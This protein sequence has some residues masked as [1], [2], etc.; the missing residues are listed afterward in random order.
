M[1]RNI[2]IIDDGKTSFQILCCFG[3]F[4]IDLSIIT[5]EQSESEPHI[6]ANIS[7]YCSKSLKIIGIEYL[8]IPEGD[9]P[10][11]P[12]GELASI[13]ASL[14]TLIRLNLKLRELHLLQY[15]QTI[16]NAV[17]QKNLTDNN[18]RDV[19]K[20]T[21]D[22]GNADFYDNF[23]KNIIHLKSVNHVKLGNDRCNHLA[24][25]LPYLFDKIET[26]SFHKNKYLH[27]WRY[28]QPLNEDFYNFF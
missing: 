10:N 24:S 22:F 26:L 17:T 23:D 11:I 21:L 16:L 20:L 2:I 9:R 18:I 1:C 15:N 14:E 6:R 12:E 7:K 5:S 13:E 3:Q 25:K 28:L 4:I 27:I 19:E 8:V